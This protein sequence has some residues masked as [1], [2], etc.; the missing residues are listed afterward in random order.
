MSQ[1]KPVTIQRA[2]GARPSIALE[3]YGTNAQSTVQR[4]IANKMAP[5]GSKSPQAE[6]K[7]LRGSRAVLGTHGSD[8]LLPDEE[9]TLDGESLDRNQTF[10]ETQMIA[11][12]STLFMALASH[13]LAPNEFFELTLKIHYETKL[14]EYLAVMG[15]IV[16]LGSWK[17]VK[18]ILKWTE[19]HIWTTEKPLQLRHKF[20]RYKYV[21]VRA[22]ESGNS[23]SSKQ[24]WEKG[25][26]RICDLRVLAAEQGGR[27]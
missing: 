12:D 23:S 24:V 13:E 19:G 8:Y 6:N 18:V 7:A 14:G 26:N 17:E 20:F 22:S 3:T 5:D 2:T 21:V 27:K 9:L 16:E 10:G 15:D 4:Y 1:S 25:Q 11:P